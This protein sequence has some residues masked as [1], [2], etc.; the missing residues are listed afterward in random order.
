MQDERDAPGGEQRFQRPAIEE[1]D[2]AALHHQADKTRHQKGGRQGNRQRPVKQAGEMAADHLLHHESGVST[3][4][5]HLAMRHVDDAHHAEG[6]GKADGGQQQHGTERQAV[7]DIL[8]VI[9]EGKRTFDAGNRLVYVGFQ[10]LIHGRG[11]RHQNADGIPPAKAL[12]GGNRVLLLVERTVGGKQRD[13]PGFLHPGP[14][15]FVRFL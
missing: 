7:P 15:L 3:D 14:H 6:D 13:S 1:A 10:A 12:D 5:H 8:G 9:P 4:H 2:D 11:R